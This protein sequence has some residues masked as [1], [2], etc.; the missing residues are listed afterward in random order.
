MKNETHTP[1]ALPL[2][3]HLRD[4]EGR[5]FITDNDGDI[6]C[7]TVLP[8]EAAAIVRACNAHDEL[9]QAAKCLAALFI[10]KCDRCDATGK[11]PRDE[12]SAC[13]DCGGCGEVVSCSNPQDVKAA[14]A[15]LAKAGGAK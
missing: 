9:L 2:A 7:R 10:S 12:T 11:E 4:S 5:Y 8:D 13:R 6:V 3:A 1:L 15:A 14:R